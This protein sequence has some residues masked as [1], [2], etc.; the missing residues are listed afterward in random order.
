[1]DVIGTPE[2]CALATKESQINMSLG[3]TFHNVCYTAEKGKKAKN[4]LHQMSGTFKSGQLT[5]I[6]G[7]SGAGKSSLMNILSGLK[8]KGVDGRIEISGVE[9][10]L[11]IF[12]K[13]SAYIEQ[14]DHLLPHLSVEEYMDAAARLKLGKGVSDDERKS[15]IESI[16]KTLGLSSSKKTRIS[17]LSGGER[18]RLSIGLE[19]FDDPSFLFL[20]EPTSGL[21]SSSS[22]QCVGLLREIARRG[23]TVVTTIHQPNSHLLDHFDHLYIVAGGSC[24]Y[25]GPVKSLVP[26]LQTFNLQCPKY[27]NP[28][29]FVMDVA[30]GDYGDILPQLVSGVDNGRLIYN[31]SSALL[32][33]ADSLDTEENRLKYTNLEDHGTNKSKQLSYAM[34]FHNQVAILLERT[35]R[36]IWREKML[37]KVRFATHVVFGIFFGLVYQSVGNDAGAVLNNIGLL[38]FSLVFIV[39]TSAMPTVVTFPLE[40]RVVFREH[41]NHWYSL[42]AYYFAKLLVDIPFQIVFPTVFLAIF[43]LMSNQPMSMDRFSMLLCITICIS[44]VGQGIGLVAGAVFD[45]QSAAFLAPVCAIPFLLFGGFFINLSAIPSYLSWLTYVSFFRYGFEG[46]M[47]SIYDY[48][49]PPL[50]CSQP[51]CHYRLPDKLLEKYDMA[52]SSYYLCIVGMLVNF[53]VLRLAGYVFLRLKLKSMH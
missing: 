46:S 35:W 27:H 31:E 34:P 28:A 9:R 11:K 29:D 42:K 2:R 17:Y 22:L 10:D 24:I 38:Y 47:L 18:K 36:T 53:V 23:R 32:C 5:A 13:Q 8:T 45:I 39:F 3:I 41:Q 49:R 30:S 51:Y 52:D 50:N 14:Y 44:L 48:N 33:T 37:T 15:K 25:Q 12:C 43:Y 26:Y 40:R 19:L 21:D 4:I 7:P 6:L 20:D 16:V 1:M